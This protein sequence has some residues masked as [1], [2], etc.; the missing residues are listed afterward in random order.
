MLIDGQPDLQVV[1]SAPSAEAALEDW[2]ALEL[3][4]QVGVLVVDIGL[5]GQDGLWLLRMVKALP[6]AEGVRLLVL[7]SHS[8]EDTV[9]LA[10]EAG[11][12]GYVLKEAAA[13]TVVD[14]IRRL[15]S[16][17]RVFDGVVAERLSEALSSDAMTSREM[18]VLSQLALGRTNQRIARE[19]GIA[20]STVKTHLVQIFQ[21]LGASDRTEAL[22]VAM[23]RGLVRVRS[24][25]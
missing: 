4:S 16:G 7:S 12:H 1:G 17:R 18:D 14:A 25:E 21:K 3:A 2:V 8:G 24:R 5:P 20:E 6:G 11:A 13:D 22:L 10:V 23:E 9:R 19:L 15:A